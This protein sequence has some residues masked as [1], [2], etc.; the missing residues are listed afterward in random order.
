MKLKKQPLLLS[1]LRS[2]EGGIFSH[3]N[4]V[5][6]QYLAGEKYSATQ[7]QFW[8][9]YGPVR[10]ENSC[11]VPDVIASDS[12][13][14]KISTPCALHYSHEFFRWKKDFIFTNLSHASRSLRFRNLQFRQNLIGVDRSTQVAKTKKS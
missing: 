11:P 12:L 7:S 6:Q 4:K 3:G 8:A 13:A 10:R 5:I 9:I 14:K 1:R 2:P